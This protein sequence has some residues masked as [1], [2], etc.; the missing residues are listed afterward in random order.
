[1]RRV[2]H[3][4][5]TLVWIV[6]AVAAVIAIFTLAATGKSYRAIGGAGSGPTTKTARALG[7]PSATRRSA[8]CSTRRTRAASAAA[9][10]LDVQA[11]VDELT[12]H[13]AA[14][15]VDK[16]L[17]EEIREHVVARNARRVRAGHKPLD[18]EAEIER[19]LRE[20]T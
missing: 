6:A 9:M 13:A 18:V 4:F 20:L 12:D 3:A 5:G 1:M 11:Q 19:Q 15:V 8:S 10:R 2:Q 7:R 16:G 17:R 14:A